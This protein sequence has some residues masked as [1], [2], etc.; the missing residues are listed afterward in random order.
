LGGLRALD[1][2]NCKLIAAAA[3]G[4][5]KRPSPRKCLNKNAD[6]GIEI[7]AAISYP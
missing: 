7:E 5:S 3:T 6:P 4:R 1:A 2:T